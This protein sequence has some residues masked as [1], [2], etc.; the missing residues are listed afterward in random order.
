[1]RQ[2]I[3]SPERPGPWRGIHLPAQVL[4]P[5][6]HGDSLRGDGH[7]EPLTA[8]LSMRGVDVFWAGISFLTPILANSRLSWLATGIPT[9]DRCWSVR[10]SNFPVKAGN[11][12]PRTSQENWRSKEMKK[13]I[14]RTF[15]GW[16]RP[17]LDIT[18]EQGFVRIFCGFTKVKASDKPCKVTIEYP[19]HNPK[20]K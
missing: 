8:Q 2:L 3:T 7:G 6:Y 10:L 12:Q 14:T 17:S 5:K 18:R 1:M 13:P 20:S 19:V 15:Y 16:F 4:C 11:E 9:P